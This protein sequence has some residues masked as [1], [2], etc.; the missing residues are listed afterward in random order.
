MLLPR[1]VDNVIEGRPIMLQGERGI[2]INPIHVSDAVG[3]L[4]AVF[5]SEESATFNVGG[6]EVLSLFEICETIGQ[7]L[8]VE[9]RYERVEGE[10]GDLV[11]DV[12]AMREKLYVPKV[13]FEEGVEDL[14][15]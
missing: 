12:S 8:G 4:V 10:G 2:R 14:L 11:G 1:L 9:P 15:P 3:A 6:T 13:R 5:D 7:R